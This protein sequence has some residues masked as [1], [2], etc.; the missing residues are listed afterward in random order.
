M[1]RPDFKPTHVCIYGAP[2][3]GKSTLLVDVVLSD[4]RPAYWVDPLFEHAARPGDVLERTDDPAR[5]DA[6]ARRAWARGDCQLVIDEAELIWLDDLP[7]RSV[8][9]LAHVGRHANV[10]L[11]LATQR[12][13]SIP[14][15]IAFSAAE[16]FAF[17]VNIPADQDYFQKLGLDRIQ[18]SLTRGHEFWHYSRSLP[19]WHKHLAPLTP[20]RAAERDSK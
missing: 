1:P 14:P 10:R 8:R 7:P 18:M 5:V 13:T 3:T 9:F 19:I 6:L 4:A 15:K 12:P 17:G 20:C 16:L 2:G 11:V